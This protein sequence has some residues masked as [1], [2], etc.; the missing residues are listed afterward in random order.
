M[1]EE[2]NGSLKWL[3]WAIP[4]GLSLILAFVTLP[5]AAKGT[6]TIPV[7]ILQ[8]LLPMITAMT[9]TLYG[10][11]V[12]AAVTALTAVAGWKVF[13]TAALPCVLFWCAACVLT[14]CVPMKQ[15]L[16]RPV[17]RTAMCLGVWCIGLITILQLT[18]GH[19]VNG[20]AQAACDFVDRSPDSTQWLVRAYSAGY[21]R[22]T[23]TEALVPAVRIMGNVTILPET[24]V[25]MLLTLRVSLEEILPSLLCSVMIYHTTLTVLLS[26]VLP[27]W[28]RRKQG[29]TG[30]FPPLER[31]YMPRRMGAAVFALC[32]GWVIALMSAD[33]IGAYLGWMCADVFRVAFM[34]QGICWM[35]WMGKRM[36]IRS[37]AR[38]AWSVVL[39]VVAPLIPMIMGVIDQR[40][41]ARHLRPKEEADQE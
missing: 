15:R 4:A 10:W 30:E 11:P 12:P 17:L 23:G 27:D 28:L 31:W 5:E 6:L 9:A 26:T 41:D 24:R 8:L 13:P 1:T 14:A 20:L 38:N 7:I 19:V 36:G 33:G 35:Q 29:G 21:V 22:L 34:I 3:A 32:I 39:S 16:L 18:G 40:R 2:R 37:V 25:Q